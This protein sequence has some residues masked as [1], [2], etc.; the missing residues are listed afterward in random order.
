MGFCANNSI[1]DLTL[2]AVTRSCPHFFSSSLRFL[3]PRVSS[4]IHSIVATGLG[5]Q[6]NCRGSR[7]P[8]SLCYMTAIKSGVPE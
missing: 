3:K 5:T 6:Q 2:V 4:S 1:A 8:I 7:R